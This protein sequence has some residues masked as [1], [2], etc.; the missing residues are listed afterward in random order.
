VLITVIEP[1][2][3]PI[4]VGIGHGEVPSQTAIL[5]GLIVVGAVMTRN[6]LHAKRI[7]RTADH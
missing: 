1:L 3:N 4:W 7:Q 2:L 5:G 6:L